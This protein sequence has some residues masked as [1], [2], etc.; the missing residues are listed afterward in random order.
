MLLRCKCQR[1]LALTETKGQFM[2]GEREF[3]TGWTL[4]FFRNSFIEF[5]E[6]TELDS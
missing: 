2:T 3:R 1:Q 6:F 4:E 5:N